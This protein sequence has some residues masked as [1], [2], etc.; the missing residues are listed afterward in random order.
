MIKMEEASD[1]KKVSEILQNEIQT[2][3]DHFIQR[4]K[5]LI[6]QPSVSA[7][8]D[9]REMAEILVHELELLNLKPSIVNH[10]DRKYPLILCKQKSEMSDL[11]E[12]NLLLMAH[13]DVQPSGDL[14]KWDSDPFTPREHNGKL[15]GRGALD[16]KAQIAAQLA[17]IELLQN[18]KLT[19]SIIHPFRNLTL[20]LFY[21]PDEEIGSTKSTTPFFH[22]KPDLIHVNGA[23]NGENS[24]E[25]I[26]LG[27]KGLLHLKFRAINSTHGKQHSGKSMLYS[28]HPVFNLAHFFSGIRQR[29]TLQL[30]NLSA[31]QPKF[32]AVDDIFLSEGEE[33][34]IPKSALIRSLS[35]IEN[36]LEQL[37]KDDFDMDMIAQLYGGLSF[38]VN[39][40]HAGSHLIE[41]S[42]PAEAEAL[43]DIRIPVGVKINNVL[44]ELQEWLKSFSNIS[45]EIIKP[46][47]KE[48][49]HFFHAAYTPPQNPFVK[50]FISTV[51]LVIDKK[52]IISP[53]SSGTSDER[54]LEPYNIPH[55][56]FGSRGAGNHGYN[57]FVY[58]DS[59][60]RVIEIYTLFLI[61]FAQNNFNMGEPRRVNLS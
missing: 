40:F 37:K 42:V 50:S 35:N 31:L 39:S 44:N 15:Y 59:F 14:K 41:T 52:P 1:W 23:I 34:P 6:S 25:R 46:S 12:R 24:K 54:F 28:S 26:V 61:K 58:I 17:A 8:G 10:I 4:L 38:N 32:R 47:K 13:F 45:M 2:R 27:C 33:I 57:E 20:T 9:V 51:E 21:N 55:V 53:F 60:F 3:K 49:Y 29:N 56:K 19:D 11:A 16:T 18:L 48:D 36:L 30:K 43:V 7:E 22:S 5:R